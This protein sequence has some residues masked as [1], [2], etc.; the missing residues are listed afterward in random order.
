MTPTERLFDVY[1]PRTAN[2]I[3]LYRAGLPCEDTKAAARKITCNFN[4][5]FTRET[6]CA[7]STNQS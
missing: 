3:Y 6:Q 1:E 7:E 2:A 4:E 5:I